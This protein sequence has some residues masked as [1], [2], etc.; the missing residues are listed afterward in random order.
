MKPLSGIAEGQVLQRLGKAG[1]NVVL[2]G[3]APADGPLHVTLTRAGRPVAG[4]RRLKAGAAKGGRFSIRLRGIPAGGPYR[5]TIE[6]SRGRDT[7]AVIRSFYVGDVWI[8]AGQSNMEGSGGLPSFSKPHRLV[9]AFSLRREWRRAEDPLHVQFESPD[10]CHHGGR[11]IERAS[12]EQWRARA[13]VGAGPGVAF[14]LGRLKATGVPQGL[15]CAALGGSSLAAWDP[16][17]GD[18]LYASMLA[19][20]RATGQPVA[21]VLWYQGESDTSEKSSA[22]YTENMQRLVAA[23]RRDLRA[24]RLPWAMVQIA[25]VARAGNGE[26]WNRVQ[27]RQRRLP[28]VIPHLAVVAAI[29]LSLDDE[30]HIGAADQPRVGARLA[31]AAARLCGG[32]AT[33]ALPALREA[34][35]TVSTESDPAPKCGID[36]FFDGIEGGLRSDGEPS[37]F[38]L[39]DAQGA[40]LPFIF[41]TTLHGDRARLHVL[42]LPPTGVRVGYGRGHFPRCNLTDGRDLAVP[43]FAPV[44]IGGMDGLLPFVTAWRVSPVIETTALVTEVRPPDFATLEMRPKTAGADGFVNE[45]EAWRGRSG[46][47]WFTARIQLKRAASLWFLMGY[48]GPFRLWLDGRAFFT[49]ARGENPCIPDESGKI[50]RLSAGAHDIAVCMDLAN[51]KSWGFFLR[52]RAAGPALTGDAPICST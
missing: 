31:H 45:H 6:D 1:A 9:R 3:E 32:R 40:E 14:G 25:R 28:E 17:A 11:Q 49:D 34:R 24:P 19:S 41:K 22:G 2:S 7:V 33:K 30:I 43:V 15:V 52:F 50:A 21:G 5:L 16:A 18:G 20:A 26:F 13:T 12:G 8:L 47:A 10:A 42:R 29:D 36:V 39:V 27:E 35:R 51:G 23:T 38:Y 44:E 46:H 48:D 37:G 4:W